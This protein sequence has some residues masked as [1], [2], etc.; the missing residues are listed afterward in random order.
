LHIGLDLILEP[1]ALT[2][3]GVYARNLVRA[4]TV[5]DRAN[6]YTLFIHH[7]H[8]PT[9]A[10]CAGES[11]R[12][13]AYKFNAS[14][15]SVRLLMQQAIFQQTLFGA[16]ARR[17]KIDLLHSLHDIAPLLYRGPSVLTVHDLGPFAVPARY[18]LAAA[19]LRPLM[20]ASVRRA[21][22]VVAVS[23]HTAQD[24]RSYLAAG[25]DRVRVVTHGVDA[26]R[27]FPVAQAADSQILRGLGIEGEYILYVGRLERGKNILDLLAAY[28]MLPEAVRA[29]LRLVLVGPEDNQAA[30]VRREA[31]ALGDRVILTGYVDHGRLGAVYR[32]ARAAVLVSTYEGFGL[33]LIEAMACGTPV[34]ASR[35]SSIPEVAASAGLL[36]E[37][38]DT[39]ALAQALLRLCTEE[40]L[41]AELSARGLERA[42][43]FTWEEAARRTLHVYSEAAR[44][45]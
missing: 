12:L 14:A 39:S 11:F 43:S 16:G 22:R 20:A 38:G 8:L 5:I 4:L 30:E 35:V 41:R 42:K 40:G 31:E 21:G 32:R 23:A 24:L 25:E 13:Q 18:G 9:F 28:G 1:T 33:P 2:G 15:P 6:D 10:A 36:V 3:T 27:F 29:R 34:V 26:S 19:Y 45:A 44:C 7:D 17:L 37:P